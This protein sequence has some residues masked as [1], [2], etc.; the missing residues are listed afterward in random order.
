MIDIVPSNHAL[1]SLE[2]VTYLSNGTSPLSIP[3]LDL[4]AELE[5]M[6]PLY[7]D[8]L[9][10]RGAEIETALQEVHQ[11]SVHS[12]KIVRRCLQLKPVPLPKVVKGF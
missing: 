3:A 6:R 5:Q 10:Q 12:A 7:A 2:I 4:L 1:S 11:I 8:E 9:L